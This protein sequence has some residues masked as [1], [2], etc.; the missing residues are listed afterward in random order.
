[1]A[2]TERTAVLPA[3]RERLLTGSAKMTGAGSGVLEELMVRV[4]LDEAAPHALLISTSTGKLSGA[5]FAVASEKVALVSHAVRGVEL[6][7]HK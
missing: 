4:E 7:S 5:S 1:M 2:L 3:L 6:D